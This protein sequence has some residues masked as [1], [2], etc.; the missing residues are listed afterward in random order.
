MGDKT[1]SV[2]ISIPDNIYNQIKDL[3]ITDHRSVSS[4][5]SKILADYLAKYQGA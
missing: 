2:S 4:M 1:K 3:A 5:I